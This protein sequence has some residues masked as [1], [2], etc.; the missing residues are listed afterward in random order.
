MLRR[1]GWCPIVQVRRHGARGW[2]VGVG[3]VGRCMSSCLR[4]SCMLLW[5]CEWWGGLPG[6]GSCMT[7]LQGRVA[8]HHPSSD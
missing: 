4:Q 5:T 1:V 2:G 8:L 6:A 7:A 3:G